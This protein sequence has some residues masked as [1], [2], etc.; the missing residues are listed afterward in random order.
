[1]DDSF[2]TRTIGCDLL[3]RRAAIAHAVVIEVVRIWPLIPCAGINLRGKPRIGIRHAI[4]KRTAISA[5]A[6]MAVAARLSVDESDFAA[7]L[8]HWCII[9]ANDA[10][11]A[12]RNE[13]HKT[14][15]QN[16]TRHESYPKC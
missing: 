11:H 9:R 16:Q 1:M 8:I 5:S 4:A 6:M 7:S 12:G 15:S 10:T 3:N 2:C 14:D 13:H